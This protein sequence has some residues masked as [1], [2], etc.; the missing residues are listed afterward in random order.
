MERSEVKIG[1][2]V[3]LW[4]D[5]SILATVISLPEDDLE[6]VE[7]RR[8]TGR[9]AGGLEIQLIS[10]LEPYDKEKF[11]SLAR[12]IQESFQ[13]ATQSIEEAFR[14][15]YEV[16]EKARAAGSYLS[17]FADTKLVSFKEFEDVLEKNGWS[18]STFWCN[19]NS[20]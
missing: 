3:M 16:T 10:R 9:Y 6:K 12:D 7:I 15:V 18:T 17:A 8:D 19:V 13:K 1:M 14:L 4:N 2:Q 20:V 11:E 5:P